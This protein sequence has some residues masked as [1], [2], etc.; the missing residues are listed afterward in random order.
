MVPLYRPFPASAAC[1][2][3]TSSRCGHPRKVYAC[4][5]IFELTYINGQQWCDNRCTRTYAPSSGRVFFRFARQLSGNADPAFLR[6]VVAAPLY[7]TGCRPEVAG[8]GGWAERE[9]FAVMVVRQVDEH[10][11]RR[12]A[13][14]AGKWPAGRLPGTSLSNT[15]AA[16][17][18]RDARVL[19]HFVVQWRQIREGGSAAWASPD[20][21]S[22]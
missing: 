1:E 11:R 5:I 16:A 21:A 13:R 4:F 12:D 22:P 14:L 3:Q 17:V 2:R 18:S 7:S 9:E 8:A 6:R 19:A 15:H 10:G 20:Q